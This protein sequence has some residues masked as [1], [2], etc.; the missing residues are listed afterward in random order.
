MDPAGKAL[1]HARARC[2]HLPHVAFLQGKAPDDWPAGRFD[3][4]LLSE[5]VYYLGPDDVPRLA[6]RVVGSLEPE[7]EVELVH[8]VRETDYPLSGDEAAERFI[9]AQPD[10]LRLLGQQRTEDYRLDLLR[11]C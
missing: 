11:R 2:R 3:L 4:I 9:A 7:G 1:G 10:A 6:A 8:W 5:V